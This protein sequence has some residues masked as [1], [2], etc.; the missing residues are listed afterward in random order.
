MLSFVNKCFDRKCKH[1]IGIKQP[2]GTELS[3][4]Y[5]C[6]AFP[7]G[8][9]AEIYLGENLHLEPVKGDNGIQFEKENS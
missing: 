2:D 5:V 3:E 6:K 7:K 8:I 4:R 1:F 9:P